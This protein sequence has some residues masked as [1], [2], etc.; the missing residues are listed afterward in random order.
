MKVIRMDE[1]E[2]FDIE[3]QEEGDQEPWEESNE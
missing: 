3:T 1:Y 2:R